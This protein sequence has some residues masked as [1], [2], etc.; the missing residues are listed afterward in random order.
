MHGKK[1][2]EIMKKVLTNRLNFDT[3]ILKITQNV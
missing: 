3:I 2:K 1:K